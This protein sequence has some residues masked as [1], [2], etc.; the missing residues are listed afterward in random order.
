M[1]ERV[2]ILDAARWLGCCERTIW[3]RI[4]SGDLAVE[5]YARRTWVTV[6]SLLDAKP[7]RRV[8]GAAIGYGLSGK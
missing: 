2:S 3:R 4:A 6:A 5:Q 8:G 1:T 7:L